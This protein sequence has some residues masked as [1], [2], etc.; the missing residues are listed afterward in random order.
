MKKENPYLNL[1]LGALKKPWEKYCKGVG[2]K[3]GAAIKEAIQQQLKKAEMLPEP[4]TFKQVDKIDEGP[5]KRFE[6]L[7]TGTE[8]KAL[9]E[10][11]E[12]E[13]CS[14]RTWVV[15]AIRV[16]LTNEPHFT[17]KEVEILGNSN[18]QLLAIGRN[19]NQ[20]AKQLNEKKQYPVS[21]ELIHN[22]RNEIDKHT[23]IVSKA[24]AANLERWTI[25]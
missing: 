17:M 9:I 5:K 22:L 14:P 4:K 12:S 21:V 18:Y 20:I 1:Y 7:L 15:D 3:P 6:I 23:D 24:I 2:K 25:E 10:R 13:M 19:L 8:K 11:A 16:G